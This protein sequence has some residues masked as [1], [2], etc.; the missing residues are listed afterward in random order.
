MTITLLKYLRS[1]FLTAVLLAVALPAP[2]ALAQAVNRIVAKVGTDVI[3]LADVT[4]A[5]QQQKI[6][7]MQRYGPKDGAEEYHK[8][9]QN[10]VNELILDKILTS[11]I[12]HENIAVSSSEIE[13]EYQNRIR[14]TGMTEAEF[15]SKLTESG[16]SVG[17]YKQNIQ[18]ELAR[19]QFVQKKIIPK[20]AISDFD[21]Q[22][23]YQKHISE[24]QTYSKIHFIEVYLTPP[25]FTS[26][27]EMMKVATEIQDRLHK[28]QVPTDLIKKYS[29]GAF[30]DKGG[31]TG[32]IDATELRQDLQK[33]LS[34]LDKGET[35]KLLPVGGGVFIFKVID[36]ADPK[37]IPFNEV[38]T[39]LRNRMGD[40]YVME[41]LKRYLMNVKDQTFVEVHPL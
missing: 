28:G 8:Y 7:L 3:T 18:Q 29:S 22:K 14:Q 19:Q 31:D 5:L 33:L 24:F 4:K 9:E 11:E 38:E 6:M 2:Q 13:Q 36:K 20:V 17:E 27:E 25:S 40:Q 34:H 23:E 32:M 12:S 10:V 37:P 41:E 1:G 30:A 39:V 26:E 16:M 15:T 21:L 35:S